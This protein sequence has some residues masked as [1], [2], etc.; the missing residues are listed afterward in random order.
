MPQQDENY[1][2]HMKQERAITT[3]D[4]CARLVRS[5]QSIANA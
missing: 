2:A 5:W 4:T 1:A 3:N